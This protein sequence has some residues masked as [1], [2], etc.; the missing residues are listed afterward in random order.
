MHQT[1]EIILIMGGILLLGLATDYLGRHSP[2]PRVSLLIIFGMLIGPHALNLI[3]A[4]IS[5]N[6]DLI[7]NMALLMVGFLLGGKI[8]GDLLRSSG[9]QLWWISLG[10]ALTTCLLVTLGLSAI[11]TSPELAILLGCI[12]AATAPAATMD[13]VV[14]SSLNNPFSRLLLS[15]VAIDDVWA[16]VLFSIGLAIVSAM[17]GLDGFFSPLLSGFWE[18]GGAILLGLIIGLPGT[19]LTGRVRPGQPT[20]LEALGLVFVCGGTAIWLEV[21]FLIAV[22]TMGM[23]IVNFAK[24]HEYP[25]HEIENI[26]SPF[27]IIFFVLAGASLDFGSLKTLG[28]VGTIYIVCRIAGKITGARLGAIISGADQPVKNW[29]G[30]ALLPQAG[31]A[32]GMAL[33]AASKFP[34]YQQTLLSVIIGSTVLFEITGPVLARTALQK[35]QQNH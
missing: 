11:G 31:V 22:I 4:A 15:I 3:P 10:A 12:A 28:L 20:L 2:L 25:F 6:F 7:T 29:M 14:E 16:L 18:I 9:N 17:N 8:S 33:L 35:S 1:S 27:M 19:Y 26:E 23:I 30:L 21:S 13:V 34:A 5:T 32:I 24:H